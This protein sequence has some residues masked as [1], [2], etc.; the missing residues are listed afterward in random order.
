MKVYSIFDDFG[1]EPA[2]ILKNKGV[3]LS[4]H[5]LGLP[6]PS[7]DEMKEILKNND[8][9]IIGTSQKITVDMFDG[10]EQPR[11]IATASVGTDH[12]NIP[13]DKRHLVTVLNTPKANAQ[14]V[15]EFTIGCAL[16]CCKRLIEGRELYKRGKNNK[17]L[18]HK[19]EDLSGKTM[20]VVGAGNISEKIMEYAMFFGMKVLCWTA[21]PDKHTQLTRKG[22]IF[23]SLETLI[24]DSDVIS[25]NLPN[26]E[27]TKGLI[28]KKLIYA[29]KENTIFISVS[30]K[31]TV[32]WIALFKRAEESPYFYVCM[33]IDLDQEISR[34]LLHCYN[35]MVTPHI[36]GGTVETRKRMFLEIANQVIDLI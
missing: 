10:I 2:K 1:E 29:M 15:A 21:H 13:K 19:P 23:A 36:A 30:R 31:P 9:I 12:I 5:P 18:S 35:I 28:S 6:R 11:I 7:A 4:V 3:Q 17:D 14:S 34:H 27:G 16:S 33:D 20:G 32:D 25:V 22:I 8:C 24:A 26:N